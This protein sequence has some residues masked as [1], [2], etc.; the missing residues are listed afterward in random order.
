M[1]IKQNQ[2]IEAAWACA[3]PVLPAERQHM[4]IYIYMCLNLGNV[5]IKALERKE[6]HLWMHARHHT[7]RHHSRVHAHSSYPHLLLGL[8][9]MHAAHV[10]MRSRPIM[11]ARGS[12]SG[13]P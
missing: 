1:T 8:G 2:V 9:R 13:L 5:F 10:G 6:C 11:T 12:G 7:I 4:C 3:M